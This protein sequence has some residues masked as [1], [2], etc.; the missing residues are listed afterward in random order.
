MFDNFFPHHLRMS[1]NDLKLPVPV[2]KPGDDERT[3]TRADSPV[4][5]R[6]ELEQTKPPPY[7]VYRHWERWAIVGLV[8]CASLFRCETLSF[9]LIEVF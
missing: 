2:K 8:S 6:E 5:A 9:R 4:N 3:L 7:S 1:T